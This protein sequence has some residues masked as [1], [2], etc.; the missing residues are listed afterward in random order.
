MPFKEKR[1]WGAIGI[2]SGLTIFFFGV[3]STAVDMGRGWFTIICGLFILAIGLRLALLKDKG[4]AG[5]EMGKGEKDEGSI[6]NVIVQREKSRINWFRKYWWLIMVAIV[7]IIVTSFAIWVEANRSQEG[8]FAWRAFSF[9]TSWSG[10]LVAAATVT[11][12]FA[13]F[14]LIWQTGRIRSVEK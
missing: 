7:T 6:P 1:F 4:K 10:V 14:L 11:L 9:L 12:A 13:T 3:N 8:L 2:G 5:I